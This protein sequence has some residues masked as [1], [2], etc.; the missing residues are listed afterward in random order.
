MGGLSEGGNDEM[1]KRTH[2]WLRVSALAVIA[3][4]AWLPRGSQASSAK[5]QVESHAVHASVAAR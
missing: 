3:A 2:F 5:A 1:S 4:L